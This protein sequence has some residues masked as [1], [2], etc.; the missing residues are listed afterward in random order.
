[1]ASDSRSFRT[2][3]V[4]L[5][6]ICA[7]SHSLAQAAAVLGEGK[8]RA[9]AIRVRTQDGLAYLH[10]GEAVVPAKENSTGHPG[11]FNSC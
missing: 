3:R 10:K 7:Q 4:N 6:D 8:L 1:M 5:H 2:V 11:S 9:C